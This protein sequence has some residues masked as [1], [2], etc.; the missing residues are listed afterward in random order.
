MR[1]IPRSKRRAHQARSSSSARHVERSSRL[2]RLFL[3]GAFPLSCSFAGCFAVHFLDC[4]EIQATPI[5]PS[6]I[7]VSRACPVVLVGACAFNYTVVSRQVANAA[8][9]KQIGFKL[10]ILGAL[11]A[12]RSSRRIRGRSWLPGAKA[13]VW[14]TCPIVRFA[15]VIVFA[16]PMALVMIL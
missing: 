8:N 16:T 9:K 15:T 6:I 7:T 13:P 4:P 10:S 12:F 1:P 3:V 2:V 11:P 5:A 14:R